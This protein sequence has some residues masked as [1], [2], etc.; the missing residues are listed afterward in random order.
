MSDI[1]KTVEQTFIKCDFCDKDTSI[2]NIYVSTCALCGKDVCNSDHPSYSQD[3]TGCEDGT[4]CPECSVNH[5]F[6]YG[7]D[8]DEQYE[9]SDEAYENLGELSGVG[10]RN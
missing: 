2:Y 10:V 8:D 5:E 9:T 3:A 7:I 4:L 6:C 1:K